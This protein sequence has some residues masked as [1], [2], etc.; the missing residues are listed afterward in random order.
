MSLYSLW[1]GKKSEEWETATGIITKSHVTDLSVQKGHGTCPIVHYQYSL[2][3]RA[4]KSDRITWG[5]VHASGARDASQQVADRY[6]EG[7]EVTV[8]YNPRNADESVLEPGPATV[9][10]LSLA[11]SCV[12]VLAG[13]FFN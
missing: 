9:T 13:I 1:K 7:M 6:R 12:P 11:V 8:Y 3:N 5:N 10:L 4:Y 2:D